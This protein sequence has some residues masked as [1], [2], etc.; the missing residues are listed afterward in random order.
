[1]HE[2]LNFE[3]RELVFLQSSLLQYG[4]I[5]VELE[6]GDGENDKDLEDIYS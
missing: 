5:K 3:F 6:P 1:M 2:V 4:E